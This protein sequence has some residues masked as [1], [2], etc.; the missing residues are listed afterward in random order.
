[1]S[2]AQNTMVIAGATYMV[3]K[4]VRSWLLPK[5][6]DIADPA[7]EERRELHTRLNELQNSTKFVMDTVT[8]C[9]DTVSSQQE[10]LNRAL[11]LISNSGKGTSIIIELLGYC[12]LMQIDPFRQ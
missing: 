9:S 10:Q 1:M 12:T 3:Y 8:T 4:F 11:T 7:E 6:F 2:A 5:F